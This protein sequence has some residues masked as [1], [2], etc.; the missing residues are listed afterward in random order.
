MSDP[1]W[2]NQCHDE[3]LQWQEPEFRRLRLGAEASRKLEKSSYRECA[4]MRPDLDIIAWAT[5]RDFHQTMVHSQLTYG[6]TPQ[7]IYADWFAPVDLR[8]GPEE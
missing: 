4:K 7:Q 5:E 2:F 8:K 3:A 6:R 1:V